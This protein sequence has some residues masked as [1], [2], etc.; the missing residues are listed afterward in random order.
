MVGSEWVYAGVGLLSLLPLGVLLSLHVA[1][2]APRSPL[3]G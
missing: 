3:L 2:V 1:F